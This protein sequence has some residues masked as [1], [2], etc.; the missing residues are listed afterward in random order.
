MEC[1][2][3]RWEARTRT[4]VRQ[5]AKSADFFRTWPDI[6]RHNLISWHDIDL[7]FS[8]YVSNWSTRGYDKFRGDPSRFTRVIREKLW[9]GGVCLTS[10]KCEIHMS[11]VVVPPIQIFSCLL[12]IY[13]MQ[14]TYVRTSVHFKIIISMTANFFV[15]LWNDEFMK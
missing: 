4:L 15:Y 3:I 13:G 12:I 10:Y 11:L 1:I 2:L 14:T 8:Q 5:I 7:K 6:W 9:G